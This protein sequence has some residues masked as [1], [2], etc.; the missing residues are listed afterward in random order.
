MPTI[1]PFPLKQF[2]RDLLSAGGATDAEAERVATSLVG[3]NLRG[4]DSHGLMRIPFYVE[5]LQKGEI[6]TGAQFEVIN[7]TAAL[8]AA[9]GHWGFGQ[10]QA[11]RLLDLLIEKTKQMGVAVGTL[12]QSS[13]IGRLGEYLETAAEQNL[14]SMVMVNTHGAARRVAPPGGKSPRLGTNPLA[15]GCPNNNT[16]LILDFSTSATAEGKVRVKHIAGQQCPEGW[17]ID[18]QGQPTTDP[19]SLYG[20]P[21]G[22]IL[23][24]GGE[25]A[26][27]GFGL[28]LMIDIFCGAL[29]GGLVAREE[30]ITPKGNCVF[31]MT[32]DPA[33]LG[34]LEHFQRETASLT[35]FVRDCPLVEGVDRITLPG[36]PERL[37]MEGRLAQGVP[38]D[39]GNWKKLVEFGDSLSVEAP[40]V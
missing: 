15:I 10:V 35:E 3:A 17:L 6:K 24:M 14:V 20:D 37:I 32:I 33:R 38:F 30:A 25:Q 16:P 29:S 23:P 34:G 40:P 19:A 11:H 8:L 26:Y 13:H 39:D 12:R 2:A 9:D 4:H 5:M 21:P 18:N 36:D 22:C 27:K 28:G 1:A 31:M 7:E